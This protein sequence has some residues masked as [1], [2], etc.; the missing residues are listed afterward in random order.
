M[1]PLQAVSA[2][3]SRHAKNARG[4]SKHFVMVA[5]LALFF[6]EATIP[7]AAQNIAGIAVGHESFPLARMQKPIT[8]AE[9]FEIK[10]T[11]WYVSA[12]FPWKFADG[13][14]LMLSKLSYKRLAFSYRNVSSSLQT[15]LT[16]A[17]SVQ[18]SFFFIDSLTERWSLVTSITPGL[19]SDFDRSVTMNDF[20]L[21]A[22]LGFVRKYGDDFQLGF[23][24]AYTRD[25][26]P[27]IPLP[28][29]Y[30][31]WKITPE[32]TFNGIV[33]V[34]FDFRYRLHRMVDLGLAVKVRGDRYHGSPL[35]YGVTNPQLEYS[36]ATV[37][38]S[39]QFHFSEWIHVHIESGVTFYRNFEFLDGNNS[40]ASYD[41][42][43]T[44]Y[45]RTE[46]VLGI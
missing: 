41:M 31:D 5:A 33:P 32:L 45:L 34:N 24:L 46:L 37:S 19:A 11:A 40:A 1:E 10:T 15:P 39:V 28:F 14:I 13:K 18:W 3:R 36:E 26:G 7:A 27:P 9:N 44:G 29:V 22:I 17:Q 30:L 21:Q 20:T 2:E 25:F 42:K 38:P 43:S 23:G 6:L 8:G 16:Q 35:K 12:A 4:R